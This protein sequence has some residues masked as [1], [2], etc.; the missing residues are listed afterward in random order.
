M[1]IAKGHPD[2]QRV[3]QRMGLRS[4]HFIHSH[5][6]LRVILYLNLRVVVDP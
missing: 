4:G 6:I 5:N 3:S 1:Q 2:N